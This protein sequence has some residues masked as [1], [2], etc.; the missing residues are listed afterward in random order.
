LGKGQRLLIDK[1]TIIVDQRGTSYWLKA[2]GKWA[3]SR[4]DKINQGIPAGAYPS[5]NL[6]QNVQEEISAQAESAA[7]AALSS[8][9]KAK[10]KNDLLDGAADE[11]ARLE[12]RAQIQGKPFDTQAWYQAKAAEIAAKYA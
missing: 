11:A 9:E 3:E 1:Q 8:E 5:D 10:Q 4:I 7:I 2:D 6:P 12:K